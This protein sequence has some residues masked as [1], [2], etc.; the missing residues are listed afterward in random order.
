MSTTMIVIVCVLVFVAL[1]SWLLGITTM[2]GEAILRRFPHDPMRTGDKVHIYI[3]GKYDR[4][5]TITR[6]TQDYI[7]IYGAVPCPLS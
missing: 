3:R 4:T 6:C 1:L 5:A 7:E 2:V